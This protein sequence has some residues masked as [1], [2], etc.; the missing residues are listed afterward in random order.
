M[1]NMAITGIALAGLFAHSAHAEDDDTFSM[2][3]G[4]IHI[5]DAGEGSEL[6]G[7]EYMRGK[8][9]FDLPLLGKQ[10]PIVGAS[11]T[12]DGANYI[13]TGLRSEHKLTDKFTLSTSMSFGYYDKGENGKDLGAKYQFR[14][15][16]RLSYNIKSRTFG[17]IDAF[18]SVEH[19]SNSGLNLFDEKI[20]PG[21]EGAFVGVTAPFDFK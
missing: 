15:D 11:Q 12:Y 17:D 16:L 2:Y 4:P 6:F 5:G 9:L 19:L 10:K 7:I 8:E 3:G 18:I 14:S 21:T 13:Y 20:N 1:K